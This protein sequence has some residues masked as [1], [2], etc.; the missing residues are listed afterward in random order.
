M[1]HTDEASDAA[2]LDS[3]L[4]EEETVE[5][6]FNSLKNMR[7]GKPLDLPL[8]V[9]IIATGAVSQWKKGA[10]E[11]SLQKFVV[12]DT[13]DFTAP[14]MLAISYAPTE[15]IEKDSVIVLEHYI[16]RKAEDSLVLTSKTKL[17]LGTIDVTRGAGLQEE[18]KA[19][20]FPSAELVSISEARTSPVKRKLTI[21]GTVLKVS[22]ISI[23]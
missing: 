21:E 16:Y 14:P 9:T 10:E 5:S 11:R 2:L 23:L 20:L 4:A 17:D 1:A 8:K 18:A 6:G 12:V 22:N 15:D 19:L 7:G 3:V 13:T